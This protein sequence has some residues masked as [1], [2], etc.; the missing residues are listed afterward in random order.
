MSN[1]GVSEVVRGPPQ[2]NRRAAVR[3][4]LSTGD[5][6]RYDVLTSVFAVGDDS[7][8]Q[9]L[10]WGMMTDRAEPKDTG[11]EYVCERAGRKKAA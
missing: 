8:R 10:G 11:R 1:D 4:M 5:D 3:K 9:A 2:A 6:G 7:A